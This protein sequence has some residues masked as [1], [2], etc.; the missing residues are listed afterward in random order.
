MQFVQQVQDDMHKYGANQRGVLPDWAN[1]D[2]NIRFFVIDVEGDNQ[3]AATEMHVDYSLDFESVFA[4][5]GD[6]TDGEGR[7]QPTIHGYD[8]S[9]MY[10]RDQVISLKRK[11]MSALFFDQDA[12]FAGFSLIDIDTREKEYHVPVNVEKLTAKIVDDEIE[13]NY[14]T[15]RL[16]GFRTGKRC[17]GEKHIS[18]VEPIYYSIDSR[19]CKEYLSPLSL[20]MREEIPSYGLKCSDQRLHPIVSET[21]N[22]HHSH[23]TTASL[24]ESFLNITFALVWVIL[25]L[26]ILVSILQCKRYC[27]EKSERTARKRIELVSGN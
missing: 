13:Y 18:Q 15:T 20:G 16:I 10:N 4:R 26:V 17:E 27:N 7:V 19:M 9:N 1:M 22:S 6:L 2:L 8:F 14:D 24:S 25:I 23:G 3:M 21:F 12:H 11:V 5:S